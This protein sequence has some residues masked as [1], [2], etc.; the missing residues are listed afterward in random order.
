MRY[1][2]SSRGLKLSFGQKS[3]ES[4]VIQN[5]MVILN[6]PRG[7]VP[8]YRE[9]GIDMAYMHN[10]ASIAETQFAVAVNDALRRFEPRA[11]LESISFDNAELA[12]GIVLPV[13]EVLING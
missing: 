5:I 2:V 11:R 9:F 7:S 6:T 10:P 13:L 3:V 8:G 4:E 1:R 12:K